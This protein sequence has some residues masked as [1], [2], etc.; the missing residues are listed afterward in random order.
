M[1]SEK[2]PIQNLLFSLPDDLIQK[3]Y[4]YDTTFRSIFNNIL[5]PPKHDWGCIHTEKMH[6]CISPYCRQQWDDYIDKL[7]RREEYY[8]EDRDEDY[9]YQNELYQ[10]ELEIEKAREQR[11]W[12]L[13][14]DCC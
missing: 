5:S 2:S 4:E 3:V 6:Q 10:K 14:E 13:N 8:Q 12:E 1:A 9:A 11:Y 7:N